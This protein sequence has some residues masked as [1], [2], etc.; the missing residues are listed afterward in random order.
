MR[1][2][3][4]NEAVRRVEGPHHTGSRR[5]SA[6][7]PP[8]AL[9]AGGHYCEQRVISEYA[10]CIFA[11]LN[12][13]PL[14]RVDTAWAGG[15]FGHRPMQIVVPLGR[16]SCASNLCPGLRV[17]LLV[18]ATPAPLLNGGSR[19]AICTASEELMKMHEARPVCGFIFFSEVEDLRFVE[20]PSPNVA[21]DP[22]F[23]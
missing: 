20:V 23:L 8:R 18:P 10:H 5:Q 4:F 2:S 22:S 21:H 15:G 9:R 1:V 12:L 13:S 7:F 3:L 16:L 11:L 14:Q 19:S 17:T 6:N